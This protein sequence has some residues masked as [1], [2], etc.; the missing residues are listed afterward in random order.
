MA[1]APVI[2][3]LGAYKSIIE[4]FIDLAVRMGYGEDFWQG[5]CEKAMDSQLAA[6]GLT[7]AEL[8]KHPCGI[9]LPPQPARYEKFV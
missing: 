5:D 6:S 8:R 9:T 2:E 7:M 3:P 1:P 4:F